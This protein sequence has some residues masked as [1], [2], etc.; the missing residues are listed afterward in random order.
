MPQV[1]NLLSLVDSFSVLNASGNQSPV[2]VVSSEIGWQVVDTATLTSLTFDL[3]S[4]NFDVSSRYVLAISPNSTSDITI[5]LNDMELFLSENNKYLSFNAKLKCDSQIEVNTQLQ[6]DNTEEVGA[7]KSLSSGRYGAIHS[8]VIFIEDEN[9]ENHNVT[10][11]LVISGHDGRTIFFTN[12]HLIDD[13]G[14]SKNPVIG[15]IRNYLPDFYWELDEQQ[16]Q[17][18]YP[19]FKFIDVL[20]HSIGDTRIEYGAMYGFE[21]D[22]LPGPEFIPEY[23]TPSSLVDYSR[24]RNDYIPW[25]SQFTGE[26]AKQNVKDASGALYFDNPQ[27]VRDFLE[28]QLRTSFLGHAGG[29]RSSLIEATRQVLIKTK[30]G[31]EATQVVSL[32][33]NFGGDPFAI[34]IKTL[35]NETFDVDNEGESS[36]LIISAVSSARPM[37]YKVTHVCENVFLFTLDDVALG[38][39]GDGFPIGE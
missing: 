16:E 38:V 3:I 24:V 1:R 26:I 15:L 34:R 11:K 5:M 6:L 35:T 21:I 28:W 13:L 17:P 4:S 12:P 27:L 31:A 23:W 29:T 36:D 2:S 37:G 30:N 39:M 18:T 10:I 25:L 8:N 9:S 14:F 33:P 7:F 32:T 19:F 22:Q 20:T